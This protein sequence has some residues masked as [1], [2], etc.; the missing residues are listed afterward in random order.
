MKQL[1]DETSAILDEYRN[2]RDKAGLDYNVFSL[3]GIERNELNTHEY[4]IFTILNYRTNSKLR[5]EFV[6]LFLISMGLPKSFQNEKWMV[7]KEHFTE[8]KGRIDLFFKTEGHSKRCVVVELKIDAGDQKLQL[9]RY[10]DYVLENTYEDYRIIYLTLDGKEPS[11]QSYEGITNPR[12]LLCRSFREHLLEWLNNCIET[13]QQ[14]D[15]DA[16][17]IQQYKI[18]IMKLVEEEVMEQDIVGLIKGSKELKACLGLV[19]ALSIVKGQLLYDFMDEIHKELQRK[20]CEFLYDDYE[21]AK[22]Y[23]DG[24]AHYPGFACKITDFVVRNKKI[25]LAL[26]IDVDIYG[27]EFYIGYF[28]E[29]Y[30]MINNEQFKNANKRIN[31]SVEDA[32]TNTLNCEIRSN[33]Y[34][35]IIFQYIVNSAGQK[36]DFK[37]FDENC[38]ELKDTSVLK[39]EAKRIVRNIMYYIKEVKAILEDEK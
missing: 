21:C 9:K 37:H 4:M 7:E 5:E 25:T 26:V 17:F 10:E 31:Q 19:E 23:Y 16:G 14:Y 6:R 15:V 3:M 20:K 32:I 34:N 27:L 11:E 33:S 28:D 39:F 2:K 8:N 30:E 38:A 18:L 35:C 13:C 22:D 12:K 36:Y 24:S 29:Q 1:I